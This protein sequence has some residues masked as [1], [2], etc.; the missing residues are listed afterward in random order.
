MDAQTATAFYFNSI[1]IIE[2][3]R[4]EEDK[5]GEELYNDLIKRQTYIIKDLKT[6]LHRINTKKDFFDTLEII[7]QACKNE[8]HFPVLHIEMH[9]NKQ[10][11]ETSSGEFIKWEEIYP[12]FES[13]NILCQNN[14]FVTLAVCSGA[15]IMQIIQIDKPSPFWGIL[16][17]FDEIKAD[18]I[19]VRFYD[20][21]Q[22]FFSSFH[23]DN[24]I[25]RLHKANPGNNALYKFINSEHIFII[26]YYGYLQNQI[27]PKGLN[28][29]A[30]RVINENAL[31]QNWFNRAE[32]RRKQKDFKKIILETKEKNY[33]EHYSK[34]MM[35]DRYPNNRKRFFV[36]E[37]TEKLERFYKSIHKDK[38]QP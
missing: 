27:K 35:F 12:F 31:N 10:G 19:R 28:E 24:A 15:H 2:S 23:I 26:A 37:T 11:L 33:R 22:E 25:E 32:R 1:Y 3:L 17:S 5:T 30:K 29:R 7:F 36:P 16:G 21:Y 4:N 9:G 20:F 34:F 13:I 8:L 38:K 14:F 18:D 6:Y